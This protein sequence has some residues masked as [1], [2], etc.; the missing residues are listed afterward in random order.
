MGKMKT[1]EELFIGQIQDLYSAEDQLIKALP[2]MMEKATDK[3]LKMAIEQHLEE[4]KVHRDRCVQILDDHNEKAGEEVCKAMQGLIKEADEHLREDMT[5]EVRDA[6][7]IACAQRVEHYEIS[8]YGT[9]STY[10]QML[11]MP[12]HAELLQM[13]LDEEKMADQKLND[14]AMSDVNM[15]ANEGGATKNGKASAST[16]KTSGNGKSSK[17]SGSTKSKQAV[18]SKK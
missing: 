3:K 6:L 10:A 14:I 1:L 9:A 11:D 15:K 2:K 12:E 13:T 8:G 7:I 5:P 16:A 4:T 18:G 17:S